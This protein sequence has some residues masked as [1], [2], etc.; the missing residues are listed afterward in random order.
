MPVDGAAA[1]VRLQPTTVADVPVLFQIESDPEGRRMAAFGGDDD[2]WA[3][4][5]KHWT[6]VLDDPGNVTRTVWWDGRVVGYVS[7]FPLFG[8][9]SVGYWIAR[10]LWGRGVATRALQALLAELPERP[11]YARVAKDNSASRRVLEKCGFRICG[12]DKGFARFRGAEV[13]E[14]VYEL[15]GPAREPPRRQG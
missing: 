7:R 10:D 2:S 6:E 11:L 13:E 14:L 8:K 5:Q 4:F 1:T 15:P 3:A 12:E 9:P